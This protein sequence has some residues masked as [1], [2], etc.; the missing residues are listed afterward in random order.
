[1]TSYSE[2]ET[3]D[4][5]ESPAAEPADKRREYLYRPVT[6]QWKK[7]LFVFNPVAGRSEIRTE[8]VDILE[9]LAKDSYA[10]TCYPTRCRG[11]ARNIVR[12]RSEHY[13]RVICAGGDGTLDEVVSGMLEHPDKP[14]VPIGYIPMGSTNDFALSLGIPVNAKAAAR[15]A[16]RG[17]VIG[18]D[19]G[20]FN[21]DTYFTYV[22]AFGLFTETSYDTSQ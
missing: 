17:K 4:L 16:A 12:N 14:A 15:V 10:V 7:A 2:N 19:L 8:L 13:V 3:Q 11:D 20:L 6:E 22:A 5:K 9:I 1:M 21:S 18:C